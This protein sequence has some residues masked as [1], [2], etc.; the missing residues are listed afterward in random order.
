[1]EKKTG[2][3][4]LTKHQGISAEAIEEIEKMKAEEVDW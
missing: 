4:F 1:V 2:L 3:D